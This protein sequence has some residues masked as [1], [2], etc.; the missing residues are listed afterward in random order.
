MQKDKGCGCRLAELVP[1]WFRLAAE[2]DVYLQYEF[3]G[4][5]AAFGPEGV[6]EM[7]DTLVTQAIRLS[8]ASTEREERWFNLTVDQQP[9]HIRLVYAS[10]GVCPVELT[11][12]VAQGANTDL[13]QHTDAYDLTVVWTAGDDP[14]KTGEDGPC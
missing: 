7:V 6:L 1:A 2:L 8:G 9:E 14:E 10:S 11:P 12:L 3:T 13:H 4:V 5:T